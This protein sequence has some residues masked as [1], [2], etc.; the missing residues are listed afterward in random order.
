MVH[1][2]RF[3]QSPRVSRLNGNGNHALLSALLTI[4]TDLGDDFYHGDTCVRVA[5]SH[6]TTMNSICTALWKSG[7][8]VLK[9]EVKVPLDFPRRS[10]VRLCFTCYEALEIDPL[11][12]EHLPNIVSAW[13]GEF[14]HQDELDTSLTFRRFQV[15]RGQVLEL[16]EENGERMA[17]HVWDGGVVLAAWVM[18]SMEFVQ[19]PDGVPLNV[20]ELGSGCGT[21]GLAFG[22]RLNCHLILTDVDD[23]ALR[24]AEKNARKSRNIFKCEWES[25]A[26]D[27]N[28]PDRLKL[29]GPLDFIVASE[30]IYNP[31]SIPGLVRTLSYLVRESSRL[32]TGLSPPKII[33][34]TKVRHSSEAA[35]FD[36][37]RK[38]GFDQKEHVSIP[39]HDQYRESIGQ[40]LELVH[41]YIFENHTEAIL[42]LE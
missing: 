37:M 34:S 10:G 21:A 41:I 11:Q 24:Y 23:D 8:R 38:S 25:R 22:M 29:D 31:D 28:E 30:C 35:F 1:Y 7:M 15:P 5:V 33:V 4:T 39:I 6:G 27:W 17:R 3:L 32:P 18:N 36:L 19:L 20:L 42:E 40:D 16:C 12:I 26:L 2:I 14:S 13:T 9:I